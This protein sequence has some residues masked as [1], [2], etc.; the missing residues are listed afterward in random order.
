MF[1]LVSLAFGCGRTLQQCFQRA[2]AEGA[3][4]HSKLCLTPFSSRSTNALPL[5]RLHRRQKTCK[6]ALP[7]CSLGT[8]ERES[9]QPEQH[10]QIFV[11]QLKHL[12][13]AAVLWAAVPAPMVD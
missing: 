8:V 2:A 3:M 12:A 6:H 11:L 13:L 4:R 5:D 7:A 9:Q 1:T 10:L